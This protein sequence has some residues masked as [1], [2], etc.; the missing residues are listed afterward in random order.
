MRR[1]LYYNTIAKKDFYGKKTGIRE[2]TNRV[3]TGKRSLI[4][5]CCALALCL[6]LGACAQTPAQTEPGETAAETMA[7]APEETPIVRYE[8][9]AAYMSA[10]RGFFEPEKPLRRAEAAQ[11]LCNVAQLAPKTMEESGYLD[12]SPADWCYEAVCTAAEYFDA[13]DAAENET[14]EPRYFRPRDEVM[15]GDLRQALV[16]ALALDAVSL[17]GGVEPADALTRADAAVLVNRALG[18]T[19]DREGLAAVSYDALLDVPKTDARYYDILEAVLPHEY[20]EESAEQWNMDTLGLSPMNKG[21]H[22]KDGSGYVVD[23]DGCVVRKSGFFT[24][25]GWTYL[26]ADDTGRILADGALHLADGH[27]CYA[28]R[29]GQLLTNGS[30]GEYQFDEN[31]FYTT[32]SEEVDA[33]LDA[34]I[35]DC[36]TE[37][38]T[39]EEMLRACYDYVRDYK[40][41][42]RNAALGEDVKTPPYEQLLDY[43]EKI[44]STGK[45]D[46]YNFAASFCLLARRL[47]FEAACVIGECTYVW[48]WKP[49]AHGWVEITRD[50]QTLLYDPQIENYNIRAQ[51]SNDDY[52]AFGVTYETAH[53]KYHKH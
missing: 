45:G 30:Y 34:A 38:M 24:V 53:A 41:L 1:F 10:S 33:L 23:E 51:I 19:P 47:G 46:C 49:I 5:W 40:Y 43:A 28:L 42:G 18:R 15:A 7:E 32:G 11:L 52:G 12:V 8:S 50:G 36:T 17:P 22:T 21:A 4:I 6:L 35:A 31:G 37:E 2:D 9:H 48:N 14:Q 16:R 29:G 13:P 3:K 27:V 20:A 26:S 25:D 44:L 39:Q